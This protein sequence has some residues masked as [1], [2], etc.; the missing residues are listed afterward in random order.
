MTVVYNQDVHGF[1]QV[2]E[3]ARLVLGEEPPPSRLRKISNWGPK[4]LSVKSVNSLRRREMESECDD[5]QVFE[6]NSFAGSSWSIN[7]NVGIGPVGKQF[8]FKTY[9]I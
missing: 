4:R 6:T 7:K 3:T 9:F 5:S 1:F 8:I 2:G